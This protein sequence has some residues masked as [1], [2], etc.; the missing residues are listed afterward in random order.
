MS[1][2]LQ[3]SSVEL[4]CDIPNIVTTRLIRTRPPSQKRIRLHPKLLPRAIHNSENHPE[5]LSTDRPI[6]IPRSSD[7]AFAHPQSTSY[8]PC[9]PYP[10]STSTPTKDSHSRWPCTLRSFPS[11]VTSSKWVRTPTAKDA[12]AMVVAIRKTDPK[13]VRMLIE[14]Q[15]G[16]SSKRQ[17]IPDRVRRSE[18]PQ[19][20]KVAIKVD[21]RDILH[22][23]RENGCV[24]DLGMR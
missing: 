17:R 2:G 11:C 23:L 8:R 21:A 7:T 10:L 9:Q 24:P 19:L 14:P 5:P 12:I 3:D 15:Q 16:S 18:Y 6:Y 4:L 13:L 22:Y 1:L 20:L